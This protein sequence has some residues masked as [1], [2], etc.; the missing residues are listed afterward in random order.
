MRW[1][2]ELDDL[3]DLDR[4]ERRR[5]NDPDRHRSVEGA[6]L[7]PTRRPDVEEPESP[8]LV[9]Y[10]ADERVALITLNRPHADNAITTEMGARLTEIVETIAVR[11]PSASS[12]SPEP[13]SGPSPSAATCA[14]ART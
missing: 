5:G 8:V 14:S 3:T 2:A 9:D 11:P 4:E 6:R 7:R 10:L 12:S 1:L 13:A